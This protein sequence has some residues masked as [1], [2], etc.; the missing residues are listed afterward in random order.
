MSEG[1][2]PSESPFKKQRTGQE[3]AAANQTEAVFGGQ[4]SLLQH[5]LGQSGWLL[6]R[7]VD[8]PRVHDNQNYPYEE[9]PTPFGRDAQQMRPVINRQLLTANGQNDQPRD[10]GNYLSH[11]GV[12][13]LENVDHM[14]GTIPTHN[15][16]AHVGEADMFVE[17]DEE[18]DNCGLS[19]VPTVASV[20]EREV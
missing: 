12:A 11:S 1:L 16:V 19:C 20:P 6:P 4:S 8:G 15:A 3:D 17:R 9:L 14:Q 5:P 7:F 10:S 2:Q 18:G 13:N